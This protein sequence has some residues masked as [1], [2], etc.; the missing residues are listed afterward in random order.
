MDFFA[1]RSSL[2]FNARVMKSLYCCFS[3]NL[4][5]LHFKVSASHGQICVHRLN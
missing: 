2:L 4:A 5:V 1:Y 3:K